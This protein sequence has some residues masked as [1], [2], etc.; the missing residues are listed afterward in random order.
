MAIVKIF[1][2]GAG[3][4][5]DDK[6]GILSAFGLR[7]AQFLA[8]LRGHN[9]CLLTVE[10]D[11]VETKIPTKFPSFSHFKTDKSAKIA[12]ALYR[13]FQPDVVIGVNTY[14]AYLATQII[15]NKVPFWAD[16]NGWIIAEMQAQSVPLASDDFL[17][18]G[19]NIERTIL[20]RADKISTV[21]APQAHATIGELGLLG[22]LSGKNFHYRFVY[23]IS[24]A[25]EK[26]KL[27]PLKNTLVKLPKNAFSIVQIGGFNAWFDEKTLFEALESAMSKNP[28]IHFITTGGIIKGVDEKSYPAFCTRVKKSLH[29][30]NF[31][32]LGWVKNEEIPMVYQVA[33]CLINVD[34]DC[35]E[36][37]MGAR[38][39]LT[40]G[41]KFG[42]PL[43]T[44]L[45]SE[46]SREITEAKAGLGVP[47]E[48][49]KA[50][51]EA[52]LALSKDRRLQNTLRQNGENLL[53]ERYSVKITMEPL[54]EWLKNPTRA[55]D[56]GRAV[57][58][59]I[60]TWKA[61]RLYLK[62]YGFRAFLHKI[63][64]KLL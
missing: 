17:P 21:S 3:P 46:I 11:A 5:P 4:L 62:K 15:D 45:G 18:Q 20:E 34:F 58:Q 61:G 22:R 9:V 28:N 7:T 54:M 49:Q 52:I 41:L 35:I 47:N 8:A 59:K 39:R 36:T 40:E 2:L 10:K 44:T 30:D 26:E 23:P 6:K 50:L 19:I 37:Q 60:N 24:N 33:D 38:N 32:L 14:P 55:P 25:A 57:P 53:K 42:I 64:E 29:R 13:A 51:A 12:H 16:L 48:D 1:L 43:M 31:H 56:R 27:K 63:R